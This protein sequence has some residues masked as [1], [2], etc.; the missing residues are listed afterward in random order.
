M[1][2]RKHTGLVWSLLVCLVLVNGLLTVPSVTHAE[3]HANHKA[4]THSTGLCAW[5]CAA[6]QGIEASSVCLESTLQLIAVSVPER[7]S[8]LA[9]FYSSLVYLRGPPTVLS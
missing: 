9:P 4:G 2:R 7:A 5:Q 6:G 8:E 1:P 3:H